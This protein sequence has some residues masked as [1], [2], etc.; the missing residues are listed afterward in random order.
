M[1]GKK[2]YVCLGAALVARLAPA[3][4]WFLTGWLAAAVAQTTRIFQEVCLPSASEARRLD[5]DCGSEPRRWT[6]APAGGRLGSLSFQRVGVHLIRWPGGQ[7]GA[8][9]GGARLEIVAPSGE[10][11]LLGLPKQEQSLLLTLPLDFIR[12]SLTGYRCKET[13][14][15]Y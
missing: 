8:G 4:K 6:L 3:G 14:R 11:N 7:G 5:V 2:V 15:V 9:R 1:N 12:D 13:S 10:E